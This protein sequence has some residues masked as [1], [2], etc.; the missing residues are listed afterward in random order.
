M[1]LRTASEGVDGC[2]KV[3]GVFWYGAVVVMVGI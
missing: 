1:E 2:I 3:V